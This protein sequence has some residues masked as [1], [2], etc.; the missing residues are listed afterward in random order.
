MNKNFRS[1]FRVLEKGWWLD[2]M[3][4]VTEE[5]II[6]FTLHWAQTSNKLQYSS[7][8]KYKGNRNSREYSSI[9]ETAMWR[10]RWA[11]SMGLSR[12]KTNWIHIW[13]KSSKLLPIQSNLYFIVKKLEPSLV[14]LAL[15]ECHL[16]AEWREDS[17]ESLLLSLCYIQVLLQIPMKHYKGSS[18]TYYIAVTANKATKSN[19]FQLTARKTEVSIERELVQNVYLFIHWTFHTNYMGPG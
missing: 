15:S 11:V 12:K 10:D 4:A 18:Y 14:S 5:K 7:P 2:C 3:R 6:T 1:N 8:R 9:L 19:S 17:F 13:I 16:S